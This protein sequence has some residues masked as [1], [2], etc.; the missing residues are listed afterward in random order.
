MFGSKDDLLGVL[1]DPIRNADD[2][3]VALRFADL[4]R[5]STET[6]EAAAEAEREGSQ[7]YC[8][9]ALDDSPG[10]SQRLA[11]SSVAGHHSDTGRFP[12]EIK[13]R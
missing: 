3:V 9:E 7:E 12:G 6:A 10:S 1:V 13:W 4:V 5:A 2:G 11:R 8:G